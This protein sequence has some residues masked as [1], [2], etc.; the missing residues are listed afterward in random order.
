LFVSLRSPYAYYSIDYLLGQGLER[1]SFEF[2]VVGL[3]ELEDFFG[4]CPDVAHAFDRTTR[5]LF[6]K[7]I[8][9]VWLIGLIPN[10]GLKVDVVFRHACIIQSIYL[11]VNHS[12]IAEHEVEVHVAVID[13]DALVALSHSVVS[14]LG[15]MSGHVFLNQDDL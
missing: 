7:D 4:S 12:S 6:G 1:S 15:P 9:M 8:D 2:D 13:P 14:D 5:G 3:L 11:D 10:R